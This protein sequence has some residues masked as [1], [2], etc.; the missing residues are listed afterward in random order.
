QIDRSFI[1]A[2]QVI[3]PAAGEGKRMGA[4]Q[5]T[6]LPELDDKTLFIHT[7]K[8]FDTD[9]RR[10]RIILVIAREDEQ[11][12]TEIVNQY[13]WNTKIDI[14][15]G[16]SERQYSVYNRL[17]TVNN[18]EI[19][20]VHEGARPFIEVQHIHNLVKITEQFGAAVLAVPVKDTIKK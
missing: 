16:G 4:G 18:T 14:V 1:M 13:E 19:V 8:V 20:L 12:M 11:L 3:L 2:Y 15:Y 9:S 17:Q 6:L 5:N 10:K 7:L